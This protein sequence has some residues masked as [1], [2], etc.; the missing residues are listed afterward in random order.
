MRALVEFSDAPALQYVTRTHSGVEI[1]TRTDEVVQILTP[2]STPKPFWSRANRVQECTISV[3]VDP[4]NIVAAELNVVAWT[5][6]AGDVD[7]YFTLNG[8]HFPIAQGEEHEVVYSKI[9]IDPAILRPG[10]NTIVLRSDTTHHGIE[11]LRPGP[12]LTI[13]YRKPVASPV[14]LDVNAVDE[15]AGDLKC[16][17]IETPRATYYLDKVGAGLSSMIDR[18][19]NDWLGFHP[20]PGSGPSGEYRGF[21]NSVFREQGSYF[22]A[23]NEGTDPCVSIVEEISPHRVVISVHASNGL[24]SGQYEFTEF[25]CTFTVTK[26]PED[27]K[28]WV[29]YEGVPGGQYDDD[30][31]WITSSAKTKNPLTV[32][33]DGDLAGPEWIAF[34]DKQL[35][36]VLFMLHHEDD[37]FPDRFYQMDRQMTVFGFGRE[38]MQKF[39][40][41]TPQ[42]FSIGF[43]ESTDHPAVAQTVDEFVEQF[44]SNSSERLQSSNARRDVLEQFALTQPGDAEA[45]EAL[46]FRDRRTQCA[47]C[48][49]AKGTGGSVGP[50]LS[51][52]GGKFD[53]PHLIES[54]MTP[55]GADCR[56]IPHDDHCDA[57]RHRT[58]GSRKFSR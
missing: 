10:E 57:R 11:I 51:T 50:D 45:G 37:D 55:V 49:R 26:M 4:A 42:S 25:A 24:W 8:R 58:H 29:L 46:F 52:I 5:G 17:K 23:R 31:W 44:A 15:S 16:F 18:D 32:N 7:D 47:T 43:V 1:P 38:G 28:Y 41:T 54:L 3:D 48:H 36:R 56:G 34:G 13:R 40:Q 22:H 2:A 39:L 6:G 33:Q 19:G 27:S 30:D 20:Q 12:A 35:D 14:R 21:P 53:R 9:A